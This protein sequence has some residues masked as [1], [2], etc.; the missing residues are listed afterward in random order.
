MASLESEDNKNFSRI[1]SEPRQGAQE[2]RGMSPVVYELFVLGELMVRPVYGYRLQE[3]AQRILG[4]LRPISWGTLYPLVR[5]F[6]REGLATSTVEKR[7]KGFP[8]VERGQPRRIY[9]ITRVGQERFF[10]LMLIHPEYGRDTPELFFIKLTKLQFLTPVQR[11]SVFRWYHRYISDLYHYYQDR[12]Q[13]ILHNMEIT[14]EERPYLLQLA[15]Y[16]ENMLQAELSWLDNV[17][18]IGSIALLTVRGRKSGE[19]RT[20]PVAVVKRNGKRYLVATFGVVNWVYNLRAAREATLAYERRSE[21]ISAIELPPWEAAPILK[22][23]LVSGSGLVRLCFEATQASSLQDLEREV[24]FH[25]VFEVSE[26]L[27]NL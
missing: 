15:D 24:P 4:P 2:T 25:P 18:A 14:E 19:L 10:D 9:A 21:P 11:I 8:Y 23:C 12:R 17:I 27:H 22:E 20:T 7:R 3:L 16:R 5:R 13:E 6:E 1:G 26:I